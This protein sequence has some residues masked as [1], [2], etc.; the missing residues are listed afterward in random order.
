MRADDFVEAVIRFRKVRMVIEISKPLGADYIGYMVRG[1]D[2]LFVRAQ[3]LCRVQKDDK[4]LSE[5]PG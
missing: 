3:T 5:A 4:L 2:S 1:V